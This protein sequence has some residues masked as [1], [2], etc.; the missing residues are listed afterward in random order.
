MRAFKVIR[1]PE[2]LKL[3]GD[4][5]RRRVV[6][7]L[8]AKEM[9]VSQIAE[10]LGKTPQAIYHHIRKLRE[11]GMVEVAREERIDHFIETYY[12][13]TAEVFNFQ[14]G[15]GA[16]GTEYAEK[17][18]DEALRNLHRLGLDVKFDKGD[19]SRLVKIQ[20]QMKE[21]GVDPDLEDRAAQMEGVGFMTKQT[22]VHYAHLLVMSDEE[23]EDYL[24]MQREFRDLL[25]SKLVEPL[26][27]P[28]S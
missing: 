23:F 24:R 28:A 15:E 18:A 17:E 26:E 6:F 11:T 10:E 3:M 13:A 2:A 1:D 19:V 14:Y 20:S 7:L 21:M 27:A 25:K 5:T 9:T 4:E 22:L 8:R 16:G 12:Q